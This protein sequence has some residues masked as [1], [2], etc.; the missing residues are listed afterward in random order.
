MNGKYEEVLFF[1]DLVF[2]DIPIDKLTAEKN[3]D[4]QSLYQQ[5]PFESKGK[6]YRCICH[7][8]DIRFGTV[9]DLELSTTR[10]GRTLVKSSHRNLFKKIYENYGEFLKEWEGI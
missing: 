1:D 2:D 10:D 8:E 5:E 6:P 7:N 3:M 9:I 4:W